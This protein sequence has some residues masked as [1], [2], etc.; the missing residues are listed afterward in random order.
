MPKIDTPDVKKGFWLAIGV[1]LAFVV[2]AVIRMIVSG[3]R[4]KS[5]A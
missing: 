5:G 3:V 2:L 4:G 1:M